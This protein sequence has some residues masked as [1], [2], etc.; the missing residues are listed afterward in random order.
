MVLQS[1]DLLVRQGVLTQNG[2]EDILIEQR[3]AGRPARGAGR[4][5]CL[6]YRHHDVERAWAGN[7]PRS[8]AA[9][10]RTLGRDLIPRRSRRFR[11]QA[12]SAFFPCGSRVM[13][14]RYYREGPPG[15]GM[16]VCGAGRWSARATLCPRPRNSPRCS[17]GT[18]RLRGLALGWWTARPSRRRNRAAR[19]GGQA[20]CRGASPRGV[21]FPVLSSRCAA[22]PSIIP[23][24]LKQPKI[25]EI[26]LRPIGV[27]ESAS[28]VPIALWTR[29]RC[30][31][32]LAET[33]LYAR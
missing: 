11:R 3:T 13:N 15:P 10:T 12:R 16:R 18:F 17:S 22:T 24:C 25:A 23:A 20:V 19:Q 1:G 5:G 21:G 33:G 4:S 32:M 29:R 27:F 9:T 7:T 30:S 31:G 26:G 14:H 28:A 8:P 6:A 2:W